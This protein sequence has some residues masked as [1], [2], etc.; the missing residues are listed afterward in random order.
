M[1]DGRKINGQAA[2]IRADSIDIEEKPIRRRG[3]HKGSRIVAKKNVRIEVTKQHSHT[4]PNQ[5]NPPAGTV[6]KGD[7]ATVDTRMPVSKKPTAEKG[8]QRL[9]VDRGFSAFIRRRSKE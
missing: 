6:V 5:E 2:T 4:A 7:H 9:N 8:G 3:M 1:T